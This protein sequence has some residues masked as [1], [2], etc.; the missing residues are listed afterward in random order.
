M[1][2]E[3]PE[4]RELIPITRFFTFSN[5]P[6]RFSLISGRTLSSVK[7]AYET[8][9]KLNK[10]GSNCILV[11]HALSGDAHAAGITPGTGKTGWWDNLIGPGKGIDTDNYFVVSSNVLGGCSGSTGP[12]SIDPESGMRYAF[13]FPQIT[14]EDMVN[15]QAKLLNFLGVERVL[16]VVGGSMGGMQTLQ[17]LKSYPGRVASAIP[18]ATALRHSA[19][20]IAFNEVGRRAITYDPNWNN[21]NYY[22]SKPPTMGLSVARMIGHITYL[23]NAIMEEKFGRNISYELQDE[24]LWPRFEVEKYLGYKGESFTRRFDANSYLYITKA[25]DLFDLRGRD[26]KNLDEVRVMGISFTSD[27]LY[28]GYQT[29]EIV[30]ACSEAG[31][32]AYHVEIDSNKGHDAFLTDIKQEAEEISKFVKRVGEENSIK[33]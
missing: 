7:I 5:Y 30:D 15:A 32:L 31:A 28:P 3:L 27:W 11:C 18:I 10:E 20:Q 1:R 2:S 24:P 22:D 9:G 8:Y 13:N 21:G 33:L 4:E 23:S 16:A 14:I 25:M 6:E 19:Q 17:W 26:L 12:S 29:S